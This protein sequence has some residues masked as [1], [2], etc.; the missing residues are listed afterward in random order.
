MTLPQKISP[1]PLVG[2]TIEI[3]FNSE[4]EKHKLLSSVF[5]NFYT[6]L[7]T[8]SSSA[9]PEQIRILDPNLR[10]SA[11]YTLSN[12]QYSMSFSPKVLSF[13]NNSDYTFWSN[14]FPFITSCL[15]KFYSLGIIKSI[16]RIGVRYASIFE[17]ISSI[18]DVLRE[19]PIIHFDN[20]TQKFG[21]YNCDLLKGDINI[22]LQI[23]GNASIAKNNVIRTGCLIDIDSFTMKN[24]IPDEKVFQIIDELHKEEKIL[25]WNLLSDSFKQKLDITY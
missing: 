8:L 12:A 7:P 9:I 16:D 18:S 4:T 13:E 5:S 19:T 14:Y 24:I 3:R 15:N 6:D 21:I 17:N 22:H 20:V 10:Y 25:F 2:S 11:D 23:A 1:N